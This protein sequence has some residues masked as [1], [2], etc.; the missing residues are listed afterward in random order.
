M[1]LQT[2]EWELYLQVLKGDADDISSVAFRLHPSF[3][4]DSFRKNMPGFTTKQTSYGGFTAELD[5][6]LS[7]NESYI[8]RHPLV[9][10]GNGASSRVT[11]SLDES[12]CDLYNVR[13][14]PLPTDMT[15]GIELELTT[16]A[17]TLEELASIVSKASDCA[18]LTDDAWDPEQTDVWR[19]TNDSSVSCVDSQPDCTAFELVSPILRGGLG[20]KAV[21]KVLQAV[22]AMDVHANNKTAG[23]HVHVGVPQLNLEQLK[24]MCQSFVKYEEACDMMVPPS[25]RSNDYCA[26]NRNSVHMGDLTN[27]QANRAIGACRNM[28]ELCEL[29]N[30]DSSKYFKLNLMPLASRRQ[31]TVEFRQHS[32]TSDYS[33]V[34]AWVR[35]L[36]HFVRNAARFDAPRALLPSRDQDYA[37]HMLFK[38]AIKDRYLRDFYEDRADELSSSCD[39]EDCDEDCGDCDD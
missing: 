1:L 17:Y 6:T 29:M 32:S 38:H 9:L 14:L 25:R 28:T 35:L 20:L 16:D 4:L 10:K 37:F 12:K 19:V 26:S 39:H 23:F 33:K 15:F 30:P 22:N 8:I 5:V 11:F 7:D 2:H 3:G 34:S 24:K 36:V 31:P 27:S 13:P 18:C 21:H